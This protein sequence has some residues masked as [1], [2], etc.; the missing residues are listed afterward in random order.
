VAGAEVVDEMARFL[1]GTGGEGSKRFVF[2]DLNFEFATTHMTPSSV[3]TLD[4]IVGL[5]KEHPD[6]RIAV[7]GYTDAIGAPEANETLSRQRA[8]AV[9][10]AMVV[11]GVAA[12]RIATR[13][14]GQEQPRGS[15]E[16]AEG[17]AQNRRTEIVVTR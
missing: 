6:A 11:R 14:L 3:V 8:E 15:N 2:D 16:T 9:K 12:D 13:G 1:E 4:R 5:L 10:D 7:E 17:R